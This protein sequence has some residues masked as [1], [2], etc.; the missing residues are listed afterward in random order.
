MGLQQEPP[1]GLGEEKQIPLFD[2]IN[3][4]QVKVIEVLSNLNE[5]VYALR[6]RLLGVNGPAG[7]A[8]DKPEDISGV[9]NALEQLLGEV[10]RQLERLHEQISTLQRL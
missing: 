8:P 4:R 6:A 9:T 3:E 5:M 2:R 1:A 10:E 7:E